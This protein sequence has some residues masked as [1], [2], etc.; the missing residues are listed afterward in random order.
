MTR[1]AASVVLVTV[2]ALLALAGSVLLY[3]SRALADRDAFADRAVEA[4]HDPGVRDAVAGEIAGQVAGRTFVPVPP[5]RLEQAVHRGIA[6]PTFERSFRRAAVATHDALFEGRHDR[7]T[8]D[9]ADAGTALVPSLREVAPSLGEDLPLRVEARLLE[10]DGLSAGVRVLRA[11]DDLGPAGPALL[12]LGALALAAGVAVA[13]DRRRGLTL[14][15]A[16]VAGAAAVLALTLAVAGEVVAETVQGAYLLSGDDVDAAVEG[17]WGAYAG[18]LTTWAVAVA[19]LGAVV[20]GG[21]VMAGRAGSDR[22]ADPL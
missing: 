4:L 10:V 9:V 3:G 14:A 13:P 2:G 8:F 12:L 1:G 22:P 17:V 7:V 19:A 15:A 6:T 18:D 16:A 11:G 20:A 21:S 5:G